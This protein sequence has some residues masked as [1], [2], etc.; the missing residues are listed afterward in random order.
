MLSA[1]A[2][3]RCVTSMHMCMCLCTLQNELFT[4]SGKK[5]VQVEILPTSLNPWQQLTKLLNFNNNPGKQTDAQ[6]QM[7]KQQQAAMRHSHQ[8]AVMEAKKKHKQ[9]QKQK[10]KQKKDTPAEAE[11]ADN[12]QSQAQTQTQ[13]P[14]QSQPQSQPQSQAGNPLYGIMQQLVKQA[15]TANTDPHRQQVQVVDLNE[16]MTEQ[17]ADDTQTADPNTQLQQAQQQQQQHTAMMS[18]ALAQLQRLFSAATLASLFNG[19]A[20][21]QIINLDAQDAANQQ[22]VNIEKPV[23]VPTVMLMRTHAEE[24]RNIM[25]NS[26]AKVMMQANGT[27]VPAHALQANIPSVLISRS[28]TH[29]NIDHPYFGYFEFPKIKT[30]KGVIVVI[31]AGP[32]SAMLTSSAAQAADAHTQQHGDSAHSTQQVEWRLNFATTLDAM[33]PKYTPF[34]MFPNDYNYNSDG[35]ITQSEDTSDVDES[36]AVID[37][38]HSSNVGETHP[39]IQMKVASAPFYENNDVNKYALYLTNKCPSDVRFSTANYALFYSP[40]NTRRVKMPKHVSSSA[41]AATSMSA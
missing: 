14:A 23:A 24:L 39:Y 8:Q 30:Y 16:L 2:F 11:P 25:A 1:S 36:E 29:T 26:V 40:Y 4:M 13:T 21:T 31:N 33:S 15:M 19:Q 7:Q 18:P 12:Q 34:F 28:W 27:H 35:V 32:W 10:D 5:T 20:A 9:L 3:M 41:A 38:E 22:T 17:Q 6:A 37:V